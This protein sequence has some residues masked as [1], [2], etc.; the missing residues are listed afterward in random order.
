[1]GCQNNFQLRNNYKQLLLK[2]FSTTSDS[3]TVKGSV[4]VEGV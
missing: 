2:T 3:K 4:F 1:M